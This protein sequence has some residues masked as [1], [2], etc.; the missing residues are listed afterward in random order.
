MTIIICQKICV[1]TERKYV[2][3]KQKSSKTETFQE[4]PYSFK[5]QVVRF[6]PLHLLW[7]GFQFYK[8]KCISLG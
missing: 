6:A 2:E 7:S 8:Q 4:F 5:Q 1:Y 3:V